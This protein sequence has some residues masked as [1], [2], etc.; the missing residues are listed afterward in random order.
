[1]KISRF[2]AE[3]TEFILDYIKTHSR[4]Q[5]LEAVNKKYNLNTTASQFKSWCN[6][7]HLKAGIRVSINKGKCNFSDEIINFII[8]HKDEYEAPYMAVCIKEKFGKEYTAK[9]IKNFKKNHGIKT[10]LTGCCNQYRPNPHKGEKGWHV[11]GSEKT[12]FKSGE[13][14][15][16]TAPLLTVRQRP[17][18][19]NYLFIKIAEPNVWISYARYLWEQ[20]NGPLKEGE[21]IK[22]LDNNPSNCTLENMMIIDNRIQGKSQN[23][24]STNPEITK[25]VILTSKLECILEDR[26]VRGE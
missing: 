11:P 6:N 8:V 13:R 17:G 19:G 2:D 15:W 4:W 1:M 10:T 22:F 5:T 16:A 18:A 21:K 12:W 14:S 24:Y 3:Q 7:R 26:K 23:R 20:T 25:A 9:Q